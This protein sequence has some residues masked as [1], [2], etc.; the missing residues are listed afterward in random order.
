RG[1]PLLRAPILPIDT[2][3]IT[4]TLNVKT[5]AGGT[6]NPFAAGAPVTIYAEGVRNAYDGVW[7]SNGHYFVPTNGSAPGGTTPGG[8]GV[9]PLNEIEETQSDFLFDIKKGGYYGHPNPLLS[10]YVLNG[11]NPTS[12]V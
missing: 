5:E 2:K 12:G 3:A 8:G 1:E 7:H 10:N 4:G 9:S 6:Y 11:G